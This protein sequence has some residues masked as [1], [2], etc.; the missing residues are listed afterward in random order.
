MVQPNITKTTW[1][2]YKELK[3]TVP[4]NTILG[5][6]YYTHQQ[7]DELSQ[8]STISTKYGR[9]YVRCQLDSKGCIAGEKLEVTFSSVSLYVKLKKASELYSD[10]F[11]ERYNYDP[12]EIRSIYDLHWLFG[13]GVKYQNVSHYLL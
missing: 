3:N 12:F 9:I 4:V 6:I 13:D 1:S 2:Q 5:Y 7:G 10:R 8:F 11:P